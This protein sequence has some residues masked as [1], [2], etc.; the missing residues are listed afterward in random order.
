MRI[1]N[2]GRKIV[3]STIFTEKTVNQR[4]QSPFDFFGSPFDDL[5]RF[6]SAVNAEIGSNDAY[7]FIG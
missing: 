5:G 4:M 1:G 3:V 6:F 7:I 2:I